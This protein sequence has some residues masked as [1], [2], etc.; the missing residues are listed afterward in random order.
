MYWHHGERPQYENWVYGEPENGQNQYDGTGSTC[1]VVNPG[2]EQLNGEWSAENCIVR[3]SSICQKLIG[4]A[5]PTGW[6]YL[7]SS[8]SGK[9]YL[10]ILNG[11]DHVPWY[12]S[13]QY[14]QSIGARSL[15]IQSESEQDSI[16][17]HFSEWQRAGVSRLWLEISDLDPDSAK[18]NPNCNFRY[19]DSYSPLPYTNWN[20]NEPNCEEMSNSCAYVSTSSGKWE[21]GN[22]A[23]LE[24]FGCE[25]EPGTMIHSVPKPTN[26]YHCQNADAWHSN[27]ILNPQNQKCYLFGR[28]SVDDGSNLWSHFAEADQ[29]CKDQSAIS[30]VINNEQEQAF[31]APRLYG[32]TW[33]NMKLVEPGMIPATWEDGTSVNFGNWYPGQPSNTADRLC[34]RINGN[35]ND[36]YSTWDA[37][38]C[39]APPCA[40][41]CSNYE[42]LPL[43]MKNAISGP[44]FP[45][46]EKPTI[47]P[48]V[49]CDNGWEYLTSTNQCYLLDISDRSWAAADDNCKSQNGQLVSINSPTLQSEL[50][51]LSWIDATAYGESNRYKTLKWLS[52]YSQFKRTEIVI[53]SN[54]LIR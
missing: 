19:P 3:K 47:P 12:S 28:N 53:S 36:H 43:C 32:G 22:C 51:T 45:D 10:F 48:N 34:V 44:S 30:L 41:R 23:G 5:C 18:P 15:H 31:I 25:V 16:S 17:R 27:W 54:C 37:I 9:C 11:R 42:Y 8:G 33:L 50:F 4:N 24:A 29:Y 20:T 2:S 40:G 35:L 13:F 46:N 1:G 14:C 21:T 38:P 6:T 52:S 26:Q 49:N 7:Q 39:N